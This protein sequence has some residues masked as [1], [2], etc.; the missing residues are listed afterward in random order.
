MRRVARRAGS[1]GHG[2]MAGPSAGRVL[3]GPL[4]P[5]RIVVDITA[6][7]EDFQQ[8]AALKA[9]ATLHR[10]YTGRAVVRCQ[11]FMDDLLLPL[12]EGG[13]AILVNYA[14][15][16]PGW[17]SIWHVLFDFFLTSQGM[18]A[19]RKVI[20]IMRDH[21]DWFGFTRTSPWKQLWNAFLEG[22]EAMASFGAPFDYSPE[23]E[24]QARLMLTHAAPDARPLAA[25]VAK[26]VATQQPHRLRLARLASQLPL[27]GHC[28]R[29]GPPAKGGRTSAATAGAGT[30]AA[31]HSRGDPLGAAVPARPAVPQLVQRLVARPLTSSV[32]PPLARQS[33]GDATAS[34]EAPGWRH[35]R[36]QSQARHLG[37][38]HTA[39]DLR[40]QPWCTRSSRLLSSP[41]GPQRRHHI[42]D[43]A[44]VPSLLHGRFDEFGMNYANHTSKSTSTE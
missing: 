3:L 7:V 15:K 38:Q 35:R 44:H 25:A 2:G 23:F 4:G 8:L 12:E 36:P 30:A 19:L 34:A 43:G 14:W 1:G 42:S 37:Q 26:A 40:T 13:A 17:P 5:D 10:T 22:V 16:P 39:A 11:N 28:L 32:R 41:R 29:G 20:G 27:L 21:P 18:Q 24:E 31:A 9:L 33:V 6:D